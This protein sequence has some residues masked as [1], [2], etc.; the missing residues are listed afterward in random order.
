MTTAANPQQSFRRESIPTKS[1]TLPF[2]P[3]CGRKAGM[4]L[5]R[6]RAARNY[7]KSSIHEAA[8]QF[9]RS[10]RMRKYCALIFILLFTLAAAGQTN[11][12]TGPRKKIGLV[13]EGGSA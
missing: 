9:C 12:Q 7:R 3:T 13:L 5:Q 6:P 11:P 4:T 8:L 1:T 10:V 2:R